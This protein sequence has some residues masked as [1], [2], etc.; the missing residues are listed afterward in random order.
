[1]QECREIVQESKN[2]NNIS[3]GILKTSEW[4]L[5][6]VKTALTIKFPFAL[7]D[8]LIQVDLQVAC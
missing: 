3:Q 1:M 8:E 4:Q 5:N 6:W 7:P 2:F